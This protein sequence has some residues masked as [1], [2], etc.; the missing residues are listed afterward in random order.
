[1]YIE[2]EDEND[3]ILYI[4]ILYFRF[5]WLFKICLHDFERKKHHK[6]TFYYTDSNRDKLWIVDIIIGVSALLI[7][8]TYIAHKNFNKY[9][10]TIGMLYGLVL[11]IRGLKSLFI[12]N[13]NNFILRKL[14]N[15]VANSYIIFSIWL[16]SA[17]IEMN[18]I[19]GGTIVIIG[20]YFAT[21]YVLW[22]II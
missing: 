10:L 2:R 14:S 7:S 18:G 5:L 17:V 9:L 11:I 4:H 15:Y 1:M 8:F 21:Y 12:R 22:K 13:P 20:L 6:K 19:E 16:L 3:E